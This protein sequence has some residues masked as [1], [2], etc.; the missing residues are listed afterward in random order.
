MRAR[1]LPE[2]GQASGASSGVPRSTSK[3]RLACTSKGRVILAS[4]KE[5][6][7]KGSGGGGYD[8]S[9]PGATE[10]VDRCRYPT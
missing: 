1:P 8:W 6:R 10:P 2:H 4:A 7:R 9:G 3:G 5:R